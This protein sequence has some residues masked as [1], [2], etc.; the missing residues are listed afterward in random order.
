M[1]RKA[2]KTTS[3]PS[4]MVDPNIL[5]SIPPSLRT[6]LFK[7]F[8]E[9]IRNYRERRW[10][11][12][13]LNGGKLSE[14]VYTILRG[15][16]DQRFPSRATK[17]RNMV[18]ACRALEQA[19]PQRFS[20]SV[21]IQ[22]PRMLVALYEIRNNRGVGHVGGDVDPNL[23]DAS[24]VL[25]MG[26]WVVAELIRIFHSTTTVE[27]ESIVETLVE[28]T[29]PVVWEVDG[30][31]RVLNPG[32]SM[33]EKTLVLLYHSSKPLNEDELRN[34]AEH[35]NSSAYRRDVL[36]KCHREKLIEFD[37]SAKRVSITPMGIR[38][39]EEKI[40]LHL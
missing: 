40:P 4:S 11:P 18:D 6:E 9:I 20:R 38:Y 33:R 5:A 10:E 14:V 15:Y 35:S 39:V 8:N 21:R 23:M 13:E 31:R 36:V 37:A 17:P 19:D 29:I 27:A 16:V 7:A 2:S 3:A 30:K 12:S 28:R 1:P 22:L 32:M 24:A 26:K 34:W 25:A